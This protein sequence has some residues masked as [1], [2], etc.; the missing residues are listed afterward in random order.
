MGEFVTSSLGHSYEGVDGIS[1]D[2][3]EASVYLLET[4]KAEVK[5]LEIWQ[6]SF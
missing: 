5:E 3:I 1:V 6:L 2:S 4:N